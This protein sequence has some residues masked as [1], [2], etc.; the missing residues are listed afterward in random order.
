MTWEESRYGGYAAFWYSTVENLG[1]PDLTRQRWAGLWRALDAPLTDGHLA[2]ERGPVL[3]MHSPG[4]DLTRN[5]A[6]RLKLKMRFGVYRTEDPPCDYRVLGIDV[7]LEETVLADHHG[8]PSPNVAT[9]G[10]LDPKRTI[11]LGISL[12]RHACSDDRDHR[13][14][15]RRRGRISLSH[16]GRF[17]RAAGGESGGVVSR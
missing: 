6:C 8:L 5:L 4:L 10:A 13:L 15:W 14:G 12:Y 7:A 3:D 16:I 17:P 1:F 9:D 2:L 11:S